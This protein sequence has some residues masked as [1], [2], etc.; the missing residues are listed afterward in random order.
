MESLGS[1][2]LCNR[3]ESG[4]FARDPGVVIDRDSI[5]CQPGMRVERALAEPHTD[6]QLRDHSVA[7][8]QPSQKHRAGKAR[9]RKE[10]VTRGSVHAHCHLADLGDRQT[11]R[12]WVAT[13]RSGD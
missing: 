11:W 6:A 12:A 8:Q 5:E 4:E 9:C 1:Q 13:A 7:S 2:W 10:A 3:V